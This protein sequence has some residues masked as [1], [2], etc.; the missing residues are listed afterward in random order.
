MK[1]D[2]EY[3]RHVDL[4]K[5]VV[6]FE[7]L[8]PAERTAV[9]TLLRSV[10]EHDRLFLRRDLAREEGIDAWLDA[11]ERGELATVIAREGSVV[12][13]LATIEP[14][15]DRWSSHVAELRVLVAPQQRGRGL[16]QLLA[17]EGFAVALSAGLEK[18]TARMTLDQ[19]AA[20]RSFESLGFK[21]EALLRDHVKDGD[22]KKHDLIILSHDVRR[23]HAMLEAYGVADA[24]E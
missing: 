9:L 5:R 10:P 20:I 16:G 24:F 18:L 3:P 7:L 1:V 17:Q 2:R 13:G 21:Q 8:S 11:H 15:R 6:R 14:E 23:F 22:G 12:I 19:D 4:Q